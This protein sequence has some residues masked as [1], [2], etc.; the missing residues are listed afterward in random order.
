MIT[1]DKILEL[2]KTEVERAGSQVALAVSIGI[3]PAYLSDILNGNRNP[4]TKLLRHLGYKRV[5]MYRKRS[6]EAGE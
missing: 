2:I 1:Q 3:T 4:S 6:A 5:M